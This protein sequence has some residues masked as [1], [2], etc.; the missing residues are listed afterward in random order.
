MCLQFSS[1]G[2]VQVALRNTCLECSQQSTFTSYGTG[3]LPCTWASAS[4]RVPKLVTSQ[5]MTL[6]S[7][8][9]CSPLARVPKWKRRSHSSWNFGE[10]RS[11]MARGKS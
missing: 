5:R 11:N 3:E 6:S 8:Q 7:R 4:Q 2:Q 10:C 9:S 1:S